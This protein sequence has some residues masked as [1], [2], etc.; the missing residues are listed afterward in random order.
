MT[1]ADILKGCRA[2][3]EF[4]GETEAAT[5]HLLERSKLPAFKWS[6][7]WRMKKSAFHNMI[8]NLETG[9]ILANPASRETSPGA[10]P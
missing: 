10:H 4:I 1:S 2:I 5:Y 7:K 6:G 9:Q 8:A 3:A